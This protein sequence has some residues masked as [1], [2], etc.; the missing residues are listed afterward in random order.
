LC[1]P[2]KMDLLRILEVFGGENQTV[3]VQ[4]LCNGALLCW[5]EKSTNGLG[6]FGYCGLTMHLELALI[7]FH[8]C[9]KLDVSKKN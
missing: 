5:G 9:L 6:S 2:L 3:G 4:M 1:K 7:K 8:L